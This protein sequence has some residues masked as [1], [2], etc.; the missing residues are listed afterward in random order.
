MSAIAFSDSHGDLC[1]WSG[2]KAYITAHD[3]GIPTLNLVL[4]F[5][6]VIFDIG[7]P[8]YVELNAVI[9]WYQRYIKAGRGSADDRDFVKILQELRAWL[10]KERSQREGKH[11]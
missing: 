1:V 7:G 5:K 11:E 2:K 8:L 4:E 9:R 10:V 3:L 6:T